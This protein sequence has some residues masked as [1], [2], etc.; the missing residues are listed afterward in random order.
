[1]PDPSPCYEIETS[2]KSSF[3]NF[4]NLLLKRLE[5]Q[6]CQEKK[7][8][9]EVIDMVEVMIVAVERLG[10]E[11]QHLQHRLQEIE[12]KLGQAPLSTAIPPGVWGTNRRIRWGN[13][14]EEI[15]Q[16][17]F[18]QLL[19]LQATG[20]PICVSTI[21]NEVPGMLRWLYGEKAVFR[22]LKGLHQEFHRQLSSSPLPL[23]HRN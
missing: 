22:G 23:L 21:K 17:V 3:P 16:C 13:S 12:S 20:K 2:F 15:R 5:D 10:L 1:M 4:R 14:P 6:Q 11:Y 9:E 8:L 7:S 19:R 18:H